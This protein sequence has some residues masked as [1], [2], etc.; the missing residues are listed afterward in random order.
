MILEKGAS[1]RVGSTVGRPSNAPGAV[2]TNNKVCFGVFASIS[3]RFNLHQDKWAQ[4]ISTSLQSAFRVLSLTR[5]ELPLITAMFLKTEGF[6]HHHELST[7]I[8]EALFRVQEEVVFC[9][10]TDQEDL[11]DDSFALTVRDLRRIT[12]AAGAL[13]LKDP[14]LD[15]L[16][17][18]IQDSDLEGERHREVRV[19]RTV[20]ELYILEKIQSY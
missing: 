2:G 12:Q 8:H 5:P 16:G 15:D 6:N 1:S 11:L 10:K 14:H 20:I 9:E 7:L 18:A 3:H 19:C 4:E 17:G 13:L